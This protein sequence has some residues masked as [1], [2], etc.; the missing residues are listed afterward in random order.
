LSFSKE[1]R[2]GTNRAWQFIA[3][4]TSGKAEGRK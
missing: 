2:F 1:T 4:G 3:G